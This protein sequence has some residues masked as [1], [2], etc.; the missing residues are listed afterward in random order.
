MSSADAYQT[1]TLW[2]FVI[3]TFLLLL[4]AFS[5][6]VRAIRYLL[7][8]QRWPALLVRDLVTIGGLGVVFA[9]ILG[10]RALEV[11]AS[12]VGNVQWA[13]LTGGLAIVSIGTY[14][15]FE[16]FIIEKGDRGPTGEAPPKAGPKP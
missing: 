16:L 13:A 6:L 11:S 14:V 8:R 12:L 7:A 4:G 2:S 9:L 15:V 3:F 10:A 1:V 5:T